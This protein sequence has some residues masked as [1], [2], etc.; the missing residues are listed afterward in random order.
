MNTQFTNVANI[1]NIEGVP[2]NEE[3]QV[4]LSV[5]QLQ[6]IENAVADLNARLAEATESTTNLGAT[7]ETLNAQIE[8]YQ[9]Q[10]D[11]LNAQPGATT[12]DGVVENTTAEDTYNSSL[13]LFNSVKSII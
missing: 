11:A 10:I 3:G 13:S 7:I 4:G 9:A 2:T 12:I 5:E 1:L 6:A 8:E